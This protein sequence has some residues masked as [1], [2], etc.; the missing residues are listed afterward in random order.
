MFDARRSVPDDVD[1]NGVSA[2]RPCPICGGYTVCRIRADGSFACCA[3][4]TSEWPL[5]NGLWLHRMTIS[6]VRER[7]EFATAETREHIRRNRA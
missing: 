3:H 2:N 7:S 1:W 6:V 4:R 5:T